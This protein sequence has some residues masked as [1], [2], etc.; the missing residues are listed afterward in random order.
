MPE[1]R[2]LPGRLGLTEHRLFLVAIILKGIDGL[3]ELASGLLLFI[4][5]PA[6]IKQIIWLWTNDELSE[7]PNNPFAHYV[8]HLDKHLSSR[9][10][11]FIALY[12]L[13]HGI[14]KLG[15]VGAM[16]RK[17]RWAYLAAAVMISAFIG[18]QVYRL[19]MHFTYLLLGL[20]IVDALIVILILL[21]YR[22]IR[23]GS[24]ANG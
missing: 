1:S 8:K 14:V 17:I 18:Y 20:T 23:I 2:F 13:L 6:W 11:L 12:L 10:T 9:T 4:V 5:G 16:L 24:A 19:S 3:V 15:L 7:E 22:H 21:E